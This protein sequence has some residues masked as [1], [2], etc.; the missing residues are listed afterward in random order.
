MVSTGQK[1][2]IGL[3]ITGALGLVSALLLPRAF[4]QKST[5][6]PPININIATGGSI[7]IGTGTQMARSRHAALKGN[8]LSGYSEVMPCC[9]N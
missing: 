6:T 3:A 2:M 4:A 1:F 5:E 8:V 9:L 7:T